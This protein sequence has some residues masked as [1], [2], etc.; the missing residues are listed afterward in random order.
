MARFVEDLAMTLPILSGVDWRDASVI[1]MPLGDRNTVNIPSL[2]GV[3]YT[4]HAGAN[5]SPE[6]IAVTRHTAGMLA[7]AGITIDERVPPRIEEAWGITQDYW[8][9][10]GYEGIEDE[11]LCEEES[12]MTGAEIEHHLFKWDRFRRT[13]IGFM[14]HYDFILTPVA[15]KP[16]RPFGSDGGGI[17]YTLPY[18]LTG[19]PCVVV[20]AGSTPDGLPVGVQIVARPWRED[21]A[22]AVAQQ[23]E[24]CSGGWQPPSNDNL[25]ATETLSNPRL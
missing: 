2:R 20:R 12:R 7:D 21:V 16:A 23:I 10:V 9:R 15:E 8:S 14:E 3:F 4:H 22:L 18:S 1:P 17:P 13:L 24:T 11:W 5:P 19:Y 25:P 6:C